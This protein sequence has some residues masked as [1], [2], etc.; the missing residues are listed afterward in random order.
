[1]ERLLRAAS[2]LLLA[3]ML[4]WSLRPV[5]SENAPVQ[6]GSPSTVRDSLPVWSVSA[7]SDSIHLEVD[8]VPDREMR[9]W[10]VALRRSGARL[11]WSG[12]RVPAT[13]V[14][15]SP[16]G[17]P[18]GGARI[19]VAAPA[20]ARV[21]ITDGLGMIDSVTARGGGASLRVRG[22]AMPVSA[23]VEGQLAGA[24]ELDS[25]A[26]R[27]VVVIGRADWESKFVIAALEESGWAVDAICR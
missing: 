16:V 2:V 27:R 10:L 12:A 23:L 11:S 26:L 19:R 7:F 14:A 13:A 20:G 9:D 5:R 25:L 3:W 1:M 21:E 22:V 24:M 15:T 18:A 8:T 17:S 6:I 4:F